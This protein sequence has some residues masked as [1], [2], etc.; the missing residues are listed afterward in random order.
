M[1]KKSSVGKSGVFRGVS[2]LNRGILKGVSPFSGGLFKGV[3]PLK[4]NALARRKPVAL[5]KL[6]KHIQK[7]RNFGPVKVER[8]KPLPIDPVKVCKDRD[9]R[10][11]VLF[12]MRKTG[13][14]SSHARKVYTEASKVRC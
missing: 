13:S 5:F 10:K 7:L 11:Q 6:P 12:S 1:S 3:S 8:R 4:S 14:N 9:V 2:P